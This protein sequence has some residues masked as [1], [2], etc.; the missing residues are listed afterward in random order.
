MIE[1]DTTISGIARVR[2]GDRAPIRINSSTQERVGTHR[3]SHNAMALFAILAGVAL[4][5]SPPALFESAGFLNRGRG[6]SAVDGSPARWRFCCLVCFGS[7]DLESTPPGS[8]FR[9]S[10]RSSLALARLGESET[11]E[12]L[13]GQPRRARRLPS[14]G[15]SRPLGP[16]RRGF[17]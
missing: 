5:S 14:M 4:F 11:S 15:K 16:G 2:T 8:N 17:E 6:R 10:P 7:R 13:T 9:A 3:P 12:R 1:I